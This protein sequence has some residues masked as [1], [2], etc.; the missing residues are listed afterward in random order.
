M[1]FIRLIP[2]VLLFFTYFFANIRKVKTNIQE[3]IFTFNK[4]KINISQLLPFSLDSILKADKVYKAK[5]MSIRLD[6]TGKYLVIF[7]GKM[8]HFCNIETSQII[9]KVIISEK[10]FNRNKLC[11]LVNSVDGLFLF[12]NIMNDGK[13]TNNTFSVLSLSPERGEINFMFNAIYPSDAYI[14]ENYLKSLI[15]IGKFSISGDNYFL[16]NTINQIQKIEND[17]FNL[18]FR[19][20][21]NYDIVK[22]KLYFFVGD[23]IFNENKFIFNVG[24]LPGNYNNIGFRCIVC[25][26]NDTIYIKSESDF[27]RYII[28]EKKIEILENIPIESVNNYYENGFYELSYENNKGGLDIVLNLYEFKTN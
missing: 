20:N 2:I 13:K 3:P 28:E 14:I 26:L 23:S 22:E 12:D 9:S 4:K 8:A 15:T 1:T 24:Q 19:R 6:F 25:V 16:N 10:D 5:H 11:F 17:T 18:D 21:G 27:W 7:D